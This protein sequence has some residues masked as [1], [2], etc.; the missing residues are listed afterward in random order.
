MEEKVNELHQH[1]STGLHTGG[2][3]QRRHVTD[4]VQGEPWEE[5]DVEKK[6][7]SFVRRSS[8]EIHEL[9]NGLG[10]FDEADYDGPQRRGDGK[11][12]NRVYAVVL[13]NDAQL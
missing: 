11:E 4:K 6:V 12:L 2:K 1:R 5:N 13:T 7:S 9:E 3:R 8:L 10:S